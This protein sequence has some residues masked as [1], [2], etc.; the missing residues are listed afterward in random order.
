MKHVL[1]TGVSTGIGYATVAELLKQGFA[2][3]GSVRKAADAQ[4][5]ADQFGRDFTPLLFDVTQEDQVRDAAARV[6]DA[7]GA[8][9]LFGLVNNAGI[10]LPGPLSELPAS[11]VRQ[12]LEV[13]V[14][15]VFHVT[16][17]FLPSLRM[18]PGRTQP[19]GRIVNISSLSGR[20]AYPFMGP[21]AASKH[22][23]EAL[24]DSWRREL[25]IYGV[26]VIVIEPGAI[27]TLIWDKASIVS[28][29]F[30]NSDFGPILED[31][32]LLESKRT[33]LPPEKV[34]RVICHA[35]TCRRPKTRYAIPDMWFKYW[36]LP[37]L[38]PDRW[39][40]WVIARTLDMERKPD[41]AP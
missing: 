9:G 16:K 14:M 37:R 8:E 12:N 36:I 6:A 22:A 40:D 32:D 39:L 24:S 23:L 27:Q 5:L 19:P 31:I 2:V 18:Q 1:V 33:A 41:V 34:A 29:D 28:T 13:N 10:S 38:L 35:L 15:G 17:A 4:R 7:V 30:A 21:Y 20:I 26:D 3:F 11:T 25:M